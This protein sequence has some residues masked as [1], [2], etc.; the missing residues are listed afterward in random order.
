LLEP[1]SR[2]IDRTECRTTRKAAVSTD[3]DGGLSEHS[4]LEPVLL[5]DTTEKTQQESRSRSDCRWISFGP[6][7][8]LTFQVRVIT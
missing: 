1:F 3:P 8:K 5:D 2:Q 4:S 6:T 7:Q